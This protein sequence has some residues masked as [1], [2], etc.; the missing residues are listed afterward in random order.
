MFV[1]E[2]EYNDIEAVKSAYPWATEIVAVECGWIVFSSHVDYE[3]W[4][5][6]V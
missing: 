5:R 3:T 2:T 6:Q 1:S 4:I